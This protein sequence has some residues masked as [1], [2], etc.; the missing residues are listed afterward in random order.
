[1]GVLRGPH[2]V[3]SMRRFRVTSSLL[4]M[5]Y[6]VFLTDMSVSYGVR[7]QTWLAGCLVLSGRGHA[8]G[9]CWLTVWFLRMSSLQGLQTLS[10]QVRQRYWASLKLC[11]PGTSSPA[12][13]KS[14]NS[15]TGVRR[16]STKRWLCSVIRTSSACRIVCWGCGR[17][18]DARRGGPFRSICEL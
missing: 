8:L 13:V 9:C 7:C 6:S 1:M 14:H 12:T 4:L 16:S 11:E 3:P 10:P 5:V 2:R 17:P 15:M 18:G